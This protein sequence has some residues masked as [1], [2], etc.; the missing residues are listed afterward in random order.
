M[1]NRIKP[2]SL[3][4]KSKFSVASFLLQRYLLV[5][6]DSKCYV[7]NSFAYALE[8]TGQ[9]ETK[10]K[11]PLPTSDYV[12]NFLWRVVHMNFPIWHFFSLPHKNRRASFSANGFVT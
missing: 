4:H 7:E 12:A 1:G 9:V 3:V 5:Y 6:K 2:P 8:K 10:P 11:K